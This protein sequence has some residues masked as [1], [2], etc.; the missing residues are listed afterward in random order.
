V[1]AFINMTGQ[2]LAACIFRRLIPAGNAERF[3]SALESLQASQL[4][5]LRASTAASAPLQQL[6]FA[7]P[8][9]PDDV[10]AVAGDPLEI[11]TGEQRIQLIGARDTL[12]VSSSTS[13]L[14]VVSARLVESARLACIDWIRNLRA[15]FPT[16]Y[17]HV[18]PDN[19]HLYAEHANV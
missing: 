13:L 16:I 4:Y 18:L 3:S 12:L 10:A 7:L 17:A 11:W 19:S 1:I 9:E 8:T 14:M 6:L 2:P 15:Q 5:G